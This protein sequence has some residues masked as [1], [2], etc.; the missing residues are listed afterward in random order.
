MHQRD[1]LSH[2]TAKTDPAQ[3]A[4]V[5]V[6]ELIDRDLA[7][8]GVF[9]PTPLRAGSVPGRLADVIAARTVAR[10]VQAILRAA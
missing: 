3:G 1:Y 5:A 10:L 7:A 4:V 8:A 9:I 2:R 6:L